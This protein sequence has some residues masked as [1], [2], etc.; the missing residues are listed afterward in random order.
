M[1]FKSLS[2]RIYSFITASVCSLRISTPLDSVSVGGGRISMASSSVMCSWLTPPCMSSSRR[3]RAKC[4]PNLV[5]SSLA[6]DK[7]RQCFESRNA[8]MQRCRR[9]LLR[10]SA[11]SGH[12]FFSLLLCARLLVYVFCDFFMTFSDLFFKY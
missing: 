9:K 6:M 10:S 8:P 1:S 3:R 12:C 5:N 11:H 2:A 4:V 7:S